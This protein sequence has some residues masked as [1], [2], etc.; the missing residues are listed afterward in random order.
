MSLRDFA[1]RC[2]IETRGVVDQNIQPPELRQSGRHE[3]FGRL[4]I[5]EM[6]GVDSG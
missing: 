5:E 1:H 4:L 2:R 6:R 3:L